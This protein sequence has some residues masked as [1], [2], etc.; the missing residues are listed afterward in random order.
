MKKPRC[1]FCGRKLVVCKEHDE[2]GWT[3]YCDHC[4]MDAGHFDTYEELLDT[5]AGRLRRPRRCPLCGRRPEVSVSSY[6]TGKTWYMIRCRH[7]LMDVGQFDSEREALRTWN[8]RA[9]EQGV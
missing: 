3:A 7:C 8:R 4:T 2:G 5:F 6:S 1:P 9:N